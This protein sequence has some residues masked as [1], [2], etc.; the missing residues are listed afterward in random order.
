MALD[1][2]E[3]T[4]IRTIRYVTVGSLYTL[5]TDNY[6]PSHRHEKEARE[7]YKEY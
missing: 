5:D 1:F 3:L 4:L 7:N 2:W 6:Y